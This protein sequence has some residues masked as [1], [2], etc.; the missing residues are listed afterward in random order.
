ML[1]SQAIEGYCYDKAATYSRKTIDS[2]IPVFHNLISCIVDK[3]ISEVTPGDLTRFIIWLQT[4]YRPKRFGGNDSPLA[5]AS[6]DL[7]WKGVRSLFHWASDVLGVKRPDLTMPRPVYKRPHVRAFTEEEVRRLIKA[8]D[9]GALHQRRITADRDK[10]FILTLLDTGL[11]LGECLRL[12]VKDI[13]LETGE[14]LVAPFGTGKKTNPRMVMLGTTSRRAVWLY[15]AKR[16]DMRQGDLLFPMS[17]NATRLVLNRIGKNAGVQ[18][19]HP[20]RFRHTFAIFYLRN[21]GD[22]FTLQRFLGHRDLAM[23]NN[24]LNLARTDLALAHRRVSA[25]DRWNANGTF[26][27]PA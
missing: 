8:C 27:Y 5:P 16:P 4:E 26:D 14:I 25:V 11:R 21:G 15:L 20:H 23:T 10:A 18:D 17:Y 3:D 19:V 1:L 6:V 24:Y 7:H 12:Q 2:Y 9:H 22:V 13:N